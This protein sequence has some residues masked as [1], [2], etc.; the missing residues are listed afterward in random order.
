[1]L[2]HAAGIEISRTLPD[3]EPKEFDL[4][5]DVK[6]EGLFNLIQASKGLPIGALV[7]FSSIAGRFGNGGQTDYSAANDLLC[8]V[9]SSMRA[10]RPETRAIAIDW[11][12]WAGI[13][14]ATRGSIPQIMELAGIDMLPPECGVPTIRRE[15][16]YGGTRGEVV[17]AQRL[18][19]M[20][21]EFDPTGGLD[22]EKVAGRLAGRARPL[23][24]LGEVKAAGLFAGLQVETTLD[25]QAQPFLAHHAMDGTPLLPGV[26][27][28]EAFAELSTLLGKD[29]DLGTHPVFKIENIQFFSPFK[30]YRCQPRTFRLSAHAQPE[31]KGG[32]A[33]HV[34]LTSLIQP[35]ARAR[36]T[37]AASTEDAA[38]VATGASP[39]P[40][41]LKLHFAADIPLGAK[42]VRA[43]ELPVMPFSVPSDEAL[44]IPA[45]DIY[46][47]YFHG[48]AYQVIEKAGVS[49][50][51]VVA[52]MT[53]NLPPA[54]EPAGAETI[55][56]PRLIELCFQAAGLW[57]IQN[58]GIM[59]LP[60]AVEC[61]EVYRQ[62]EEAEGR[63][64][65]ALVTAVEEGLEF[66][67]QVVDET[68]KV[69]VVL[70]GY[71]T[72][73]LPGDVKLGA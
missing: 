59:A 43:D 20:G 23:P 13:G 63:R 67:A 19:I 72:V 2:L 34:E 53:G 71:R 15:L 22:T 26:M 68:G 24:M 8:K 37:A 17:V 58:K 69:Y 21:E 45:A 28:L 4:V 31:Q 65:Y 16:T 32:L 6:A 14:M 47:V 56:A 25:P 33:A 30:Y 10:W 64:L 46:R 41:G 3:K 11:T 27:G 66:N 49:G 60:M 57:L 62:P 48:P 55:M 18:G 38:P 40:G 52:L 1:M 12:A 61:V 5:L 51:T 50:E 73:Q 54:T 29:R 44:S 36:S 39:L 35:P 7:G 70:T 9:L 42:D